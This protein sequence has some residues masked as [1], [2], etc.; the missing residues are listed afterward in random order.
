MIYT[1]VGNKDYVLE[2]VKKL[3]NDSDN[4]VSYDMKDSS[5]KDAIIDLDTVSLFG[6][7]IVKVFNL[8]KV[9]YGGS[10]IKYLDNPGSNT[11]ILISYK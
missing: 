9:L 11:L 6:N 7:K 10:L 8:D 2:E 3:E 4:I 1:L 5:L